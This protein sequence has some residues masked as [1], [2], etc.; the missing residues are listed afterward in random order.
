MNWT[1]DNNGAWITPRTH[2]DHRGRKWLS[3]TTAHGP[4]VMG[5][6]AM[7]VIANGIDMDWA[8]SRANG[9]NGEF[10]FGAA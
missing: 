1:V 10:D 4:F 3:T 7:P 9:Q 8:F 6:F 5:I 2:A